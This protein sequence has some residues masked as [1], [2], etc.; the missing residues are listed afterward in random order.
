LVR[1]IGHGAFGKVWEAVDNRLNRRVAIKV[2]KAGED[3]RKEELERFLR[4]GRNAANLRHPNIV[5]VHD[6]SQ[7]EGRDYIVMDFVEG[8]TL[9][10]ALRG[11]GLTYRQKVVLLEKTTRAVQYAH[12][13]GVI[14]RDLKPHNIMLDFGRGEGS[15]RGRRRPPLAGAEAG[16]PELPPEPA[17]LSASVFLEAIR[18]VL[19][20]GEPTV[21]RDLGDGP[22]RADK[23]L[24]SALDPRPAKVVGGGHAGLLLE[25][26][27]EGAGMHIHVL[28]QI[29]RADG[30]R[31]MLLNE[32][33]AAADD[34]GHGPRGGLPPPPQQVMHCHDD[35][36]HGGLQ[37]RPS[38]GVQAAVPQGTQCRGKHLGARPESAVSSLDR[39]S[40][41][42]V[43]GVHMGKEIPPE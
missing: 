7:A 31:Q 39:V 43:D 21:K 30:L 34:V 38:V 9:A 41:V 28:N 25:P 35:L 12:E 23:Q 14:H 15:R 22:V 32:P 29:P 2:V 6:V 3:T 24:A 27:K 1:P 36:H 40:R 19:A 42:S 17:G 26:D 10:E 37:P 8:I 13:Q 33:V 5:P 20:A 16:R 18:E 11:R 4:E